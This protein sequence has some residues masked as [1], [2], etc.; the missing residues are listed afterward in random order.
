MADLKGR[1]GWD[2]ECLMAGAKA[3]KATK[4]IK[5]WE[6]KGRVVRFQFFAMQLPQ[7]PSQDRFH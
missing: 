1:G 2:E 4:A 3:F 6:K 5:S 7:R